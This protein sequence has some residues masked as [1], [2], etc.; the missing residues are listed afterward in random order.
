ML[1]FRL[2]SAALIIGSALVFVWL[3][4]QMPIGD[5]H[6]FWMVPLGLL[7]FFGS[8]IE[9]VRMTGKSEL[10]SIAWPALLGCFGVMAAATVPVYWPLIGEPYPVDC[11]LGKLGWPLAASIIALIACIAWYIPRYE[12]NSNVFM[13]A[14]LAG[15]VSVYFGGCFAFAVAIRLTGDDGWG[16]YLL[17]GIITVTKFGDAGAYFSGRALGRNKLCP[18]V[19][20]GK[21]L[22][23]LVGGIV[24]ATLAGWIYFSLAAPLV[25]DSPELQVKPT[26]VILL[27]V[28]LTVVGVLG[29]LI[30]SLFK[31]EMGCKDSGAMLPGLGGIWD[32]TDSL[33]PAMVIGYLVVVG[34]L[35]H[36]PGQ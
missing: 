27:G 18:A 5:C 33:L 6:G 17:V 34:D 25:F 31:R 29:D 35:I 7:L 36:G 26:G 32:V 30:E 1:R 15:W 24:V 11:R 3:D 19:S 12:A 22:E 20:P 9:C 8:A 2:L 10:G 23:G 28:S 4:A 14:I 13:R 21:T 16:L